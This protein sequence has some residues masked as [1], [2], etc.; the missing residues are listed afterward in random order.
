MA[1]A[2]AAAGA[3]SG[4]G[5]QAGGT[6]GAGGAAGAG[7]TPMPTADGYGFTF[8]DVVF[9]ISAKVGGRVSKLALGGTD[10]IMT[11]ATD[12]TTWG[13]GVLDQPTRRLDRRDR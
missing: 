3:T 2:T 13:L 5:G 4:A 7:A 11:S 1:A 12:P 10:I 6:G 9:E 8:G